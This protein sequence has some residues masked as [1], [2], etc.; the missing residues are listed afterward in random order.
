MAER[1][2]VAA[3]T[4][5]QYFSSKDELLAACLHQWLRRCGSRAENDPAMDA[6]ERI[7]DLAGAVTAELW[8]RPALADALVRGYLS[9]DCA[10]VT[11]VDHVRET[12]SAMMTAAAGRD[13]LPP[14][15]SGLIA[16]LWLSNMLALIQSRSLTESFSHRL[17]RLVAVICRSADVGH[18]TGAADDRLVP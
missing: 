13:P 18:L 17:E 7:V 6:G 11:S 12:L 3:S 10:A 16:D 5:Y 4:V 2:E 15:A 9:A 8:R 1:A 14:D